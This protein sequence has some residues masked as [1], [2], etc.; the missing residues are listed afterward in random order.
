[1]TI[2]RCAYCKQPW[3]PEPTATPAPGREWTVVI[4]KKLLSANAGVVNRGPTRWKYAKERDEWRQWLVQTP[5]MAKL[6]WKGLHLP[7]TVTITRLYS[8]REREMDERNID[9]KALVDSMVRAGLLVDDSPRWLT[10]HVEQE[11]SEA[12]GVRVRIQEA[13]H[14]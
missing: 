6:P 7:R 9:T 3:P 13:G 2:E 10:L 8:G 4:P 1:M 11:R 12:S 5:I 14:G